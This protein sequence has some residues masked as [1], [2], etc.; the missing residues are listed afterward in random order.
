[1]G[2]KTQAFHLGFRSDL[3]D[4]RL[5]LLIIGCTSAVAR[6]DCAWD[7]PK[8][9]RNMFLNRTEAARPLTDLKVSDNWI[10]TWKKSTPEERKWI[11]ANLFYDR[12][13]IALSA[14]RETKNLLPLW[15][16]S[17]FLFKDKPLE[18]FERAFEEY[19][20]KGKRI[21]VEDDFDVELIEK[22]NGILMEEKGW[23]KSGKFGK[24]R[25]SSQVYFNMPRSKVAQEGALLKKNPYL[26]FENDPSQPY[27]RVFYP[28]P[29]DTRRLLEEAM[30]E[31]KA[32]LRSSHST[33]ER[34]RAYT[35]FTQKLV[36]I[37]P[38]P[39]GNGRT[40][41]FTLSYLLSQEGLPI[42]IL[43]DTIDLSISQ[44]RFYEKVM[45]GIRTS[46]RFLEDVQWRQSLGLDIK[47]TPLNLVSKLPDR[48]RFTSKGLKGAKADFP[49]DSYD[50]AQYV[51]SKGKAIETYA[52]KE[53]RLLREYVQ[54]V[55]DWSVHFV[56]TGKETDLYQ[57]RRVP[58]ES[59]DLLKVRD[60]DAEQIKTFHRDFYE[61]SEIH[62]GLS[63]QHS[64]TDDELLSHFKELSDIHLSMGASRVGTGSK[65]RL[66]NK[67]A[68]NHTDFNSMMQKPETFFQHAADHMNAEGS[69]GQSV[70]LSTSKNKAVAKRFSE[71]FLTGEQ[72]ILKMKGQ[73]IL[74]ALEPKHG[75]V[76]FNRLNEISG[77]LGNSFMSKYPRQQEVAVA[78]AIHPGSVMRVE[79]KDVEVIDVKRNT[80][81]LQAGTTRVKQTRVL[82]RL[83]EDPT[84]V[85]ISV[86]DPEGNL[87]SERIVN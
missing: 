77:K 25:E 35:D 65:D 7:T 60:F 57:V 48:I 36:S 1:M 71:G 12:D 45:T 76:D 8:L 78:G 63:T 84:K 58:D 53:T 66:L 37:H 82:E 83:P 81:E 61:N 67:I 40:T 23:F 9:L 49:V 72:S 26:T 21:R 55:K 56:K 87:I 79:F 51:R 33:E 15:D 54:S 64:Y 75:A 6:A 43:E 46:N 19:I 74:T 29:E 69:Y 42:P 2:Q 39:D 27:Q 16:E 30:A 24:V 34:V 11:E 41:R 44:E 85:K 70:F 3:V 62:R 47:K 86:F 5:I 20:A 59:S 4:L 80:G 18:K 50:Y 17:G 22:F 10:Q 52:P 31:M 38:F 13:Q 14:N 73:L 32:T 68:E 28:K